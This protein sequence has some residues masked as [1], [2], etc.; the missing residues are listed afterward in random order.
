MTEML[1][2]RILW[3]G[4]ALVLLVCN[5]L[6]I[7]KERLL[8]SGETLLL[9]LAPRDPRS[10]MQGDY[11][12]LRYSLMRE[13]DNALG[14]QED[15]ATADG[16]VIATLDEDSVARFQRLAQS[17]DEAGASEVAM[18]YRIRGGRVK[19]ASDAFFFQEGLGEFY[20]AARY[21]EVK[22]SPGGDVLL[23]GLRDRDKRPMQPALIDV[24]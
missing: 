20:E 16:Y 15:V 23:V 11:M 8:A 9:E 3:G 21:G 10:I 6:I 5:G 7:A 1:R 18:L 17:A 24:E 22:V 19:I 4:L 12:R 13:I 14:D 2:R